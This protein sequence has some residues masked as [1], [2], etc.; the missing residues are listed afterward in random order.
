[1]LHKLIGARASPKYFNINISF[2]SFKGGTSRKGSS[3]PE[4]PIRMFQV[5]GSDPFN[6]KAIEVPAL[7]TSLNS[8]DVFLLKSQSEVYLWC[9]KVT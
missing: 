2:L 6:T 9:G 3:N 4:P 1:M 5:H 7:A 8:N